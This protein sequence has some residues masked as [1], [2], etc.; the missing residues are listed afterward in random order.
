M[1]NILQNNR[2]EQLCSL[3]KSIC[4]KIFHD[5]PTCSLTILIKSSIQVQITETS[6]HT[7]H[8]MNFQPVSNMYYILLYI[9]LKQDCCVDVAVCP[10][11]HFQALKEKNDHE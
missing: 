5:A 1:Q 6:S 2:W 10:G 8:Q 7:K 9:F 4:Y 11:I 3:K